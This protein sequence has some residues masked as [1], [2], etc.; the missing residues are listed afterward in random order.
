MASTSK[1][2]EGVVVVPSNRSI[3]VADSR[4]RKEDSF[5]SPYDFRCDLSGTGIY[6]KELYYQKL[7]W[8][9]PLFSHNNTNNEIRFRVK[10]SV[11]VPTVTY[12]V[13]VTPF[14]IFKQYDGN[15]ANSAPLSPPQ[16][17]SYAA[18]VEY[19]F[20]NDIRELNSNQVLINA[21]TTP[22]RLQDQFGNPI[23]VKFRYSPSK[24]FALYLVQDSVIQTPYSIQL[25]PCSW[26]AN[27]HFVHGFGIYDPNQSTT[28][29]S[30]HNFY[31]ACIW[32]D[33]TPNL[34]PSR[35][36][37]IQS[38]ELNKDRRLISFH[39]GNFA[40][41]IN[42]LGI[43]SINPENSATY[44]EVS[45][46]DDATV[47]SLRDEYTPQSFRI[48]I[49]N[50][51]G[52]TIRCGDPLG[53]LLQSNGIT[54]SI[55]QSY[56][57]PSP[58]AGRG[59]P[60]FMNYLVFGYTL[61]ANRIPRGPA[62]WQPTYNVGSPNGMLHTTLSYYP[63]NLLT[64]AN[65]N[66]NKTFPLIVNATS[67]SPFPQ[68]VGFN[69]SSY[70]QMEAPW[71]S[72]SHQKFT[73][74]TWYPNLN[75]LPKIRWDVAYSGFVNPSPPSGPST[76]YLLY[77]MFDVVTLQIIQYL[78]AKTIPIPITPGPII[79]GF[80]IGQ[81]GNWVKNPAYI[82]PP[83]PDCSI[84]VGFS[85]GWVGLLSGYVADLVGMYDGVAP[86]AATFGI[87]NTNNTPSTPN[88]YVPPN[89]NDGTYAFGDPLASALCE[90][91]IHEIAAVLKYN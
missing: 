67:T 15:P 66:L 83:Q 36:I 90:E 2:D 88:G 62:Y 37:V 84:N 9:Q 17:Y 29:M 85:I 50:E 56:L 7:Y 3:I 35:Y 47:I 87:Q 32:S 57:E 82:F 45:V 21:A 78:V 76:S 8:N 27:A 43:F 46:G 49:L 71:M 48:S 31:S 74:F 51:R 73:V 91:V 75:P 54:P 65:I 6:S 39:N 52:E 68:G 23:T 33:T 22:G 77:I 20:N 60:E 61:F 81:L 44:H 63:I 14:V 11:L 41:F 80:G 55:L 1:G 79:V 42:E 86:F 53:R 12:V 10:V 58:T 72:S 24:G 4:F 69:S 16:P 30:P 34:L 89:T 18:N 5:E 40:N 13:Y 26:I 59:N 64:P 25:Y 70:N 28:T 38:P 19:A